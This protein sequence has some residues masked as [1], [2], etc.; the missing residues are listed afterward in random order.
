LGARRTAAT[1]T[2]T[3]GAV[4]NSQEEGGRTLLHLASEE[5]H[6]EVVQGLLVLG[7]NVHVRDN[8]GLTPFQ[9]PWRREIERGG[10]GSIARGWCGENI[11]L[12]CPGLCMLVSALYEL[13]QCQQPY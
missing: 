4:P 3:H 7:A 13:Y 8:K 11:A 12:P 5:G 1:R 10:R 2:C 6:L 9:V